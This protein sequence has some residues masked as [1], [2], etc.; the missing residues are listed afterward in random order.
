MAA[1][2]TITFAYNSDSGSDPKAVTIRVTDIS[3]G[4]IIAGATVVIN[5]PSDYSFNGVT[6]TSG[7]V[8]LGVIAPGTYSIVTTAVGFLPSNADTVANDRFVI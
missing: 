7:C 2:Q 3:T 6:D 5:G 8:A 4:E 1:S